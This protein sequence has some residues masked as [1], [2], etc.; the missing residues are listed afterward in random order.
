MQPQLLT[1]PGRKEAPPASRTRL[2][3]SPLPAQHSL[4]PAATARGYRTP[5]MCNSFGLT[6]RLFLR[7]DWMSNTTLRPTQLS[8]ACHH[9]RTQGGFMLLIEIIQAQAL[10]FRPVWISRFESCKKNK[11]ILAG[12]TL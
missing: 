6:S 2:P 12:Q 7:C 9:S 5:D 3:T 8:P 10:I 4:K 1:A 11:Q